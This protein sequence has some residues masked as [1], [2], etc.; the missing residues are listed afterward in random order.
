MLRI[1]SQESINTVTPS[2]I[3][4]DCKLKS[5]ILNGD[6]AKANQILKTCDDMFEM[7][8]DVIHI[9]QNVINPNEECSDNSANVAG[10]MLMLIAEHIHAK[11]EDGDNQIDTYNERYELLERIVFRADELLHMNEHRLLTKHQIS[12]KKKA[13]EELELELELEQQRQEEQEEQEEH[14]EHV[15]QEQER[16]VTPLSPKRKRVTFETVSNDK[17]QTQKN[18]V[19]SVV[20]S[21]VSNV[22]ATS[23]PKTIPQVIRK[24]KLSNLKSSSMKEEIRMPELKRSK[25]N[26]KSSSSSRSNSSSNSSSN[27]KTTI[28]NGSSP[29][30]RHSIMGVRSPSYY[31]SLQKALV[32]RIGKPGFQA[33]NCYK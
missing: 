18:V 11:E 23:P 30:S 1:G 2:P 21:M 7:A 26:N 12:M 25:Q 14:E 8:K 27:N 19:A 22:C 4:E 5:A 33:K 20:H 29:N 17:K 24:R 6:L 32:N 13:E 28:S 9:S 15:A 10:E 16:C 31:R 3:L